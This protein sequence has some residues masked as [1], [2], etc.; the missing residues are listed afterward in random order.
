[1]ERRTDALRSAG[2][3]YATEKVVHY[4]KA[5]EELASLFED[6][7]RRGIGLTLLGSRR[8]FGEQFIPPEGAEG[9]SLSRFGGQVALLEPTPDGKLWVRAPGAITFRELC[10]AVPGYLPHHPPTGDRISL[11]G[12]LAACTHDAVGYFADYVRA[13]T[14]LSPDGSL[15]RCSRSAQGLERELFHVVVGSFGALGA[16]LDIEICL[17]QLLPGEYAEINVLERCPTRGYRALERL[18]ACYQ[19]GLYP[20]GR[21]LFFFGRR[22]TSV[23]LGDRVRVGEPGKSVREL[24]LTDDRT[25]R[26][27]VAQAL[28]NRLPGVVHRLQPLVFEPG[29]QFRATPYG[30]S[31]YQRSYDRAQGY[32]ASGRTVPRLL[33]LFGV[34]P[35]L[36]VCH[37]T[38]VMPVS[39]RRAFMDLYFA[40]FDDFPELESRLEQQ[41]VIRL[42][43]CAW[44]LHGAAGL[45]EGCFLLTSSFSVRRGGATEQRARAFLSEVSRRAY[46]ELG[47]RV[48]LLKQAHC[49][50]DLLR[51]MHRGFIERLGA[52]KRRLDPNGT[53]RSTLLGRLGI[54]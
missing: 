45:A 17:R 34:N 18:E 27:I 24:L 9:V 13:F 37:Q 25:E 35:W 11:G 20:L 32:L 28:A 29:R 10:H 31:F 50:D 38:F 40:V 43:P 54:V 46:D 5:P 21:G 41:D 30:F 6:A 12:A 1:M 23:L 14:L 51:D 48:L 8:S 7:R 42:P 36:G 2:G 49:D 52:M 3:L 39:A 33:G 47:V 26:N 16:I 53:L 44:P 19:V 22:R 4:P 15:H